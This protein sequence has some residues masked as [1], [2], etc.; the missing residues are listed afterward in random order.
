MTECIP[1]EERGRVVAHIKFK[2]LNINLEK[3]LKLRETYESAKASVDR[4]GKRFNG[5][6]AI[7]YLSFA[8]TVFYIYFFR[9]PMQRL[10]NRTIG[11]FLNP[12][13]N[14]I[15][16]IGSCLYACF[17]KCL[18][19]PEE[20]RAIFSDDLISELKLQPLLDILNRAKK[21]Y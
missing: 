3:N 6:V 1:I 7:A 5:T 14:C 10:Y 8:G 16:K 17:C 13:I 20:N 11:R 4:F 18:E 12:F 2:P 21:E 15:K 19:Q 9:R